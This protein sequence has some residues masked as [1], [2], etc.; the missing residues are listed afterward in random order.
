M[1]GD[2]HGNDRGLDAPGALPRESWRRRWICRS[3]TRKQPPLLQ[4]KKIWPPAH[5]PGGY[6]E[7]PLLVGFRTASRRKAGD[8]AARSDRHRPALVSGPRPLLT[9]CRI[10]APSVAAPPETVLPKV[11][12]RLFEECCSPAL[13]RA[14]SAGVSARIRP[15]PRPTP[16]APREELVE[17]TEGAPGERLDDYR[18]RKGLESLSGELESAAK[19]DKAPSG[20]TAA[21]TSV[22]QTD[23]GGR[24][25][26]APGKPEGLITR[27]SGGGQRLWHHRGPDCD[28]RRWN[29]FRAVFWA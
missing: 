17:I 21:P 24:A 11:F 26:E 1:P 7:V 3:C 4:Q 23:A 9:G 10:T 28:R 15:T 16:P 14:L 22:S 27:P 6:R 29:G 20:T 8:R 18:G 19:A 5:R 25:H 13:K 12:R 2:A